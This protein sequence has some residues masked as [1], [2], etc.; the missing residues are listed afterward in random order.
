MKCN[1]LNN[2][3]LYIALGLTLLGGAIY[4]ALGEFKDADRVVSVRGLSE[5]E[6]AADMVLWPIAYSITGDNVQRLYSEI[7]GKNEIILEFLIS[8]GIPTEDILINPAQ[9]NDLD[10][11]RYS[12]NEKS[13]RYLATQIITVNSSQVDKVIKLQQRQNEL[14]ERN[15]VLST[16]NYQYATSFL[17]TGLNDIKPEMIAE[18]TKA[19]RQSAE[20]FAEDSGSEVGGIKEATQGLFSIEDRDSYT[21]QIKRIRV[22]TYIKYEID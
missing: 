3:G 9:V 14:L 16:N 5:R 12:V 2:L 10:T 15:V 13:Y 20:E 8:A 19:A 17:F 18:A 4:L 22:V 1:T 11:D 6:V 7:K 21:P